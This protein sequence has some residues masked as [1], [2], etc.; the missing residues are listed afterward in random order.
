M[1]TNQYG[2]PSRRQGKSR[3]QEIFTRA[4]FEKWYKETYWNFGS[5]IWSEEKN[6]YHHLDVRLAWAAYQEGIQ[7]LRV[8][9]GQRE[10]EQLQVQYGKLLDKYRA[11]RNEVD[12]LATQLANAGNDLAV[13]RG[14]V[15]HW[16]TH[17]LSLQA[18]VNKAKEA[19][20]PR[21]A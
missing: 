10:F 11:K 18:A 15:A 17:A 14:Q 13:T 4:R 12:H 8:V 6:C 5:E 7:I 20:S 2:S 16:Q 19:L 9:S 21:Y 3:R 1:T